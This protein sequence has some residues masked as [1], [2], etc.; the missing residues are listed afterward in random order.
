MMGF[1][2]N[3]ELCSSTDGGRR[4]RRATQSAASAQ[5]S[6]P[7]ADLV[8]GSPELQAVRALFFDPDAT[9]PT[10]H[11]FELGTEHARA[12]NH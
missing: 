2:N 1:E 6:F 3:K 9:V 8:V 10:P 12:P 7:V 5:T 11:A 4:G